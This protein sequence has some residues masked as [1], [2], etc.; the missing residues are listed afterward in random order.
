LISISNFSKPIKL[1]VEARADFPTVI[2]Q[3]EQF[4][5]GGVCIFFFAFLV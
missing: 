2:V 1:T 3:Q 5:F 4:D